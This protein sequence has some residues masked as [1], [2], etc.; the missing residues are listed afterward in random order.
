MQK[1]LLLLV[2]APLF[3][4]SSCGGGG[5]DDDIFP[6]ATDSLGTGW[7]RIPTTTDRPICDIH[8]IG[9]TGFFVADSAIFKSTDGGTT[10]QKIYQLPHHRTIQVKMGS[11]QNVIVIP[12]SGLYDTAM[13]VS[14]NGGTSFTVVGL[15]DRDVVTEV[16]FVS[17]TLV[18][19]AGR[20]FYKSTNGGLT[21]STPLYSFGFTN[22]SSLYFLNAS[23]GW[24][25]T[26]VGVF[27]TVN[28]GANWQ[29]IATHPTNHQLT[30]SLSF[31]TTDAG[32]AGDETSVWKTTNNGTSWTKL[33]EGKYGVSHG[34]RFFDMNNGYMTD[35]HIYKTT[36]GGQ[37]WVRDLRIHRDYRDQ[38]IM[39]I[40]FTDPDHGWAGGTDGSLYKYVK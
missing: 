39:K 13:Y 16:F 37:T 24:V 34:L 30:T 23:V 40:F 26:S 8:F 36:D 25:S 21:W 31:I 1:L 18:Y 7:T 35:T 11:A 3:I 10:W 5:N 9:N 4:L 38:S 14:Q 27:K 12:A 17:P 33:F 19:A 29:Q 22:W 28:G 20:K 15:P 2:S 32:Y 6:A